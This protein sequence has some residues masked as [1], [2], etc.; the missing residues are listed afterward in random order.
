MYDCKQDGNRFNS[1]LYYSPTPEVM[2]GRAQ[3]SL[4]EYRSAIVNFGT[5]I[6]IWDVRQE[7]EGQYVCFA[8]NDA[9]R[10]AYIVIELEVE[11]KYLHD[12]VIKW[13]HFPRYWPI[14]WGI[15]R[16]PVNSPHK[17]Q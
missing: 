6:Y 14:V 16:S 11:G 2:F 10:S 17:G 15:H 12:D 7:D 5:E 9:G 3:E 8:E 13:K 1:L 4:P